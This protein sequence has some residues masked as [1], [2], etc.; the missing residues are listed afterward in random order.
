M[1][2]SLLS[3]IQNPSNTATA[4]YLSTSNNEGHLFHRFGL[5][6]VSDCNR[7]HQVSHH[8]HDYHHWQTPD[9]HHGVPSIITTHVS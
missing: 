2:R 5:G 3:C 9:R 1:A 4:S 7:P 6:Y 8:C